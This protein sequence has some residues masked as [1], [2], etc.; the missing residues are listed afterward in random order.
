MIIM[1]HYRTGCHCTHK[2]SM[3]C[4]TL[5][6]RVGHSPPHISVIV[7]GT[8]RALSEKAPHIT[9]AYICPQ[10]SDILELDKAKG[11]ICPLTNCCCGRVKDGGV[12]WRGWGAGAAVD[13]AKNA[14][15][16]AATAEIWESCMALD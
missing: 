3:H 10:V 9:A 13:T 14:A 7:Q 1:G 5:S 16:A 4:L 2:Q 8:V 11:K 12:A 6:V 15:K